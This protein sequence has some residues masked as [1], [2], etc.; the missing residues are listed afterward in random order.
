MENR[1]GLFIPEKTQLKFFK[2]AMDVH[3]YSVNDAV[4]VDFGVFPSAISGL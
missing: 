1:Y 3:K 4:G 2:T